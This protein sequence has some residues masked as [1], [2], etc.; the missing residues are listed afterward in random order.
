MVVALLNSY[1][2]LL[3]RRGT[4]ESTEPIILLY[5]LWCS[6]WTLWWR[7]FK[8]EQNTVNKIYVMF[9]SL[10]T[11]GMILLWYRTLLF[12]KIITLLWTIVCNQKYD[13][14]WRQTRNTENLKKQISQ[15]WIKFVDVAFSCFRFWVNVEVS[16]PFLNCLSIKESFV[17]NKLQTF[18][19]QT[20]KSI[21]LK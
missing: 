21:Y 1:E 3:Q 16:W 12:S 6:K 20:S 10:S 11:L 7:G 14:R 15:I 9:T 2:M 5:V 17:V 19:L 18:S 8:K 13:I 4:L